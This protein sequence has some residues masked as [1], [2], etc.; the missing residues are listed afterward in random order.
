MAYRGPSRGQ[1]RAVVHVQHAVRYSQALYVLAC[2]TAKRSE[3][4]SRPATCICVM[5]YRGPSRGQSRAVVH[6]QHAVRH[7]QVLYVLA[8]K[9]DRLVV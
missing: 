2:K 7:S 3:F 9:T 8:R 6:V 1:T 5:A 4:R